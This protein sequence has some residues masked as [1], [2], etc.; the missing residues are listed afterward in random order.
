MCGN[1][2][3]RVTQTRINIL[4]RCK[5]KRYISAILNAGGI[6]VLLLICT[7]LSVYLGYSAGVHNTSEVEWG[8]RAPSSEGLWVG[9]EYLISMLVEGGKEFVMPD[10]ETQM[11]YIG[12]D[13]DNHAIKIICTSACEDEDIEAGKVTE[14][15][16][17]YAGAYG[18]HATFSAIGIKRKNIEINWQPPSSHDLSSNA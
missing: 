10:G 8:D 3:S 16:V 5:M 13:K 1:A 9:E 11:I 6:L 2:E 15:R 17:T 18:N 12:T 4:E 7:G 14:F